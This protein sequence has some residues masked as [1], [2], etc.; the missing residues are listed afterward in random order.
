MLLLLLLIDNSL[1]FFYNLLVTKVLLRHILQSVVTTICP[2]FIYILYHLLKSYF[3]HV[4]TDE[5][6][7]P[8]GGKFHRMTLMYY[9]IGLSM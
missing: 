1:H 2:I 7:S 3:Y 6:T 5:L 9:C 4:A 8:N